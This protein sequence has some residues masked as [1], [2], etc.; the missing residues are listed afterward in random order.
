LFHRRGGVFFGD[1]DSAETLEKLE[2]RLDVQIFASDIDELCHRS[3]P[4]R[5]LSRQYR[6]D[7]SK[8]RLKLFF[9]KEQG[10]FKVKKQVRDMIVFSLQSIIKDPPFS[11]LDLVSCRNLLIYMDPTLQKKIIP[12]LHYALN[13][14]G[15]L[16]LG[17]AETIGEFGD[18][19]KPLDSKWKIYQRK[20][21]AANSHRLW[22][23]PGRATDDQPQS[24]PEEAPACARQ[25]DLQ[26][27]TEKRFWNNTRPRPF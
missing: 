16:F 24:H 11:K 23:L 7:V 1:G 19:F 17:S 21:S 22:V 9:T 15:V 10:A 12:L 20:S 3:R 26:S 2:K 8:K 25:I 5:S 14:K 18:L 27:M 13:P 6:R 4:Q